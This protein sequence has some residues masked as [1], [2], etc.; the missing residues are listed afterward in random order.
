MGVHQPVATSAPTALGNRPQ[1]TITPLQRPTVPAAVVRTA[2]AQTPKA[3]A[4]DDALGAVRG[5]H[6]IEI[7]LLQCVE[8]LVVNSL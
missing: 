3:L 6:V 4:K 8:H 7:I 2:T 1:L 5:K